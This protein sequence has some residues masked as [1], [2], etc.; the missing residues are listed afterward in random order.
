[1]SVSGAG[2]GDR[3][4]GAEA[5]PRRSMSLAA[6]RALLAEEAEAAGQAAAG[7]DGGERP[8]PGGGECLEVVVRVLGGWVPAA[9]EAWEVARRCW[10]GHARTMGY[11]EE[12]GEVVAVLRGMPGP[13]EAR[14]AVAAAATVAATEL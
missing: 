3:S 9:G 13:D 12:L 5:V 7:W 4:G 1:M 10:R 11:A 14:A 8:N 2:A 6:V